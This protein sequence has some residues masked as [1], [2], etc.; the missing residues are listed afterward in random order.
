MII[1]ATILSGATDS[2]SILLQG[3]Q[4]TFQI[5]AAITGNTIQPKMSN[6]G[7]NFTSVGSAIS[8]SA[9]GTYAIPSGCFAARYLKLV[10]ASSEGADRAITVFTRFTGTPAANPAQT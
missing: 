6:D 4:G 10:S 7:T 1:T 8:V 3:D 5:P 9:N 2:Q